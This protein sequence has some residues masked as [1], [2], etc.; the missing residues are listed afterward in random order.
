MVPYSC[1][2]WYYTTLGLVNSKGNANF[3]MERS[4]LYVYLSSLAMYVA[5]YWQEEILV[6]LQSKKSCLRGNYYMVYCQN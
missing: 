3:S 5:L 4:L 6:G 2:I 1:H